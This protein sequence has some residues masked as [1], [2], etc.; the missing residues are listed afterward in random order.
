MRP[1]AI[2]GSL[3]LDSAPG[4]EPFPGGCPYH[5]ARALSL[6]ARPSRIVAK[7]SLAHRR[8]LLGPVLALGIPVSWRPAEITT[9]F[10]LIRDD[11]RRVMSVTSVGDGWTADEARSWVCK[12]LEPCEWVHVAPLLRDEFSAAALAEIARG[13]ILSLDGQ[14]LARLPKVGP[15]ELDA[16]FDRELLRPVSVL[17]LSERE[18]EAI[19]HEVS[20]ESLASLEVPEVI[21]TRGARGA[22][23]W[24]AGELTEVPARPALENAAAT[25]AGD[26]FA[27]IYIA[28]RSR[29][30]SPQV[31]ARRA[32]VFV[33]AMLSRR[34]AP[35][36]AQ[37]S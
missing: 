3:S 15:L 6:L 31:A 23:V 26:A 28:A 33:G 20:A 17:K 35:A 5:A 34:L 11:D 10:E 30:R 19:L 4:R 24:S 25:G 9:G 37:E 21:V 7:C 16:D 13:R 12:A 14:G 36:Q 29:G 1:V 18:A 2:V 22:L 8:L 32:S 27:A